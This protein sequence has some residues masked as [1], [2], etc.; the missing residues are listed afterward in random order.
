MKS[1]IRVGARWSV[2]GAALL[3]AWSVGAEAEELP[4]ANRVRPAEGLIL[5]IGSKHT[6]SY[7]LADGG[8][9]NLTLVVGEKA[10]DEG[11]GSTVGARIRVAIDSGKT[12]RIETA[13]G[14]SLEFACAKGAQA[15][16]VRR[17]DTVAY[18]PPR[19]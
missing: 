2:V 15:I 19:G 3:S 12:A 11:D 8:T 14:K 17:L 1:A 6:V 9:C 18:S 5:D 10:N 4:N 7:F 16:G 13:E